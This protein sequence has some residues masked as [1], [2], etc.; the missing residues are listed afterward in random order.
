MKPDPPPTPLAARRAEGFLTFALLAFLALK[1]LLFVAAAWQ[2]R[3]IMDEMQFCTQVLDFNE[4][5]YRPVEPI[6]TTLAAY[7]FALP[8]QTTADSAELLLSARLL[9]AALGLAIAALVYLI[10]RQLGARPVL[11]LLAVA[12]LT[13][14]ST[15][16]ERGFRIRA[17]LFSAFLATLGLAIAVSRLRFTWRAWALGL[18][19]GLAFISTQKSIYVLLAFVIATALAPKEASLKERILLLARIFCGW[20]AVLLA[21]AIYFGG[22]EFPMVL[23]KIFLVPRQ[24]A[25]VDQGFYPEIGKYFWSTLNRN[26]LLWLLCQTGLSSALARYREL[27]SEERWAAWATIVVA[28]LTFNHNQPWPYVFIL[29]VPFSAIWARHA[30]ALILTYRGRYRRLWLASLLL[31]FLPSLGRNLNYISHQSNE[32]QLFWVRRAESLLG[33]DERYFDGIGMLPGHRMALTFPDWWWDRPT[34]ERL[35]HQLRQGDH[36]IWDRIFA[37]QPKILLLNYRLRRFW[38]KLETRLSRSYARIDELILV[39]GR[40][41]EADDLAFSF[42][43]HWAGTY[44]LYDL[45]GHP[46]AAT[47]GIGGGA[48]ALEVH[49]EKG[50]QQI[51]RDAPGAALLLPVGIRFSHPPPYWDAFPDLFVDVYD[52]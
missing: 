1:T 28:M 29:V 25:L 50:L 4:G 31:L 36:S 38:P 12:T 40:K 27:T 17:D 33:P 48:K 51:E 23:T 18:T 41:L 43:C 11:A 34:L 52:F 20:A 14:F 5:L 22:G 35:A 32:E 3:F 8:R 7:Y 46:L 2:V 24:L 21:Y 49:L 44:R 45:A 39:A 6:K 13:T 9:G 15:F 19:A 30:F 26:A 16:M 10:C 47:F 42:D 37:D